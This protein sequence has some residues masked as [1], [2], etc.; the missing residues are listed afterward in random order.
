[1]RFLYFLIAV[2]LLL[3]NCTNDLKAPS[4]VIHQDSMVQIIAEMHIADAMVL[5]QKFQNNTKKINSEKFYNA[6][7]LKHNINDTIFEENLNYLSGDTAQFKIV[8][9]K[10]IELLNVMQANIM[11][12]DSTVKK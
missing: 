6:I 4:V 1:M 10:V 8:Y 9:D 11:S 12:Q 2:V 5:S 7:L 3:T